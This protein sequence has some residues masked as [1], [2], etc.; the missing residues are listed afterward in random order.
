MI[1][2][3]HFWI[4]AGGQKERERQ[5]ILSDPTIIKFLNEKD[6]CWLYEISDVLAEDLGFKK[7]WRIDTRDIIIAIEIETDEN[8]TIH[9]NSR[10]IMDKRI[11]NSF[12]SDGFERFITDYLSTDACFLE[13]IQDEELIDLLQT[14]EGDWLVVTDSKTIALSITLEELEEVILGPQVTHIIKE[15]S[16][17]L[18]SER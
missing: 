4:E 16:Y 17:E 11:I 10:L 2:E 3:T 18:L 7:E 12:E 6:N 8:N 15:I 1:V 14:E 9:V 13:M 5:A